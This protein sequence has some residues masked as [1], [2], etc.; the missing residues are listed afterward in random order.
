MRVFVAGGTGVLGRYLVPRL[1]AL[2]HQVGA[3]V[4]SAE[5][6]AQV[7]EAGATPLLGDVLDATSLAAAIPGHDV[8]IHAATKLPR[9]FPGRPADF[10]ATDRIRREGTQHLL[11]A[12]IAAGITRFVLQSIVWVHGDAGDVWLDEGAVLRP[13]PLAR[14]AVDAEAMLREAAAHH[15]LAADI[16]RCGAFYDA[17]SWHTRE[18]LQRLRHRTAPIIGDGANYQSFVH[19]SDAAEAFALAAGGTRAGDTYFVVDDEPVRLADYLR[20]LARAIGAGAPLQVPEFLA[21]LTLGAAMADAYGASLRCGNGR[22]RRQLSWSPRFASFRAGYADD[23]LPAL[24]QVT[25]L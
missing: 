23:V 3:L 11:A 10:A 6:A 15:G 14:S 16:L 25:A 21:R 24:G 13:G 19:V 18:I 2:G 4:R 8:V 20:W 5:G 7:R 22:A 12:A 9:A 1:V 17:R